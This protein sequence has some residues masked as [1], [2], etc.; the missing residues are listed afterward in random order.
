L[1]DLIIGAKPIRQPDES[2]LVEALRITLMIF[3]L[4]TP[5]F[6]YM[7]LSASHVQEEYRLSR[8]VENRLQLSKEHERLVLT[9][10]ALLSPEAVNTIARD[11]LGMVEEDAQE[12]T[13]GVAP[14]KKDGGMGRGGDGEKKDPSKNPES[15]SAGAKQDEKSVLSGK[16]ASAAV[17][18][19]TSAKDLGS[20][21][22]TDAVVRPKD[23]GGP[24]KVSS[25]LKA[26]KIPPAKNRK[27]HPKAK[28][29]KAP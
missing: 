20:G 23:A 28:R 3:G 7:G 12:W 17:A 22:V 26:H 29:G 14:D 8:L 19:K 13:V 21:R 16:G 2:G 25:T 18:V 5:F 4:A 6:L 27:T 15:E 24:Q 11:K 10:D 1:S 9:R